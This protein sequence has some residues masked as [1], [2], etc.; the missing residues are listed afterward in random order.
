MRQVYEMLEMRRSK[1]GETR[2]EREDE[3]KADQKKRR[4]EERKGRMGKGAG[5]G[6]GAMVCWS[7]QTGKA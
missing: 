2:R 5:E 4:G 3:S 1:K 7:L 6:R